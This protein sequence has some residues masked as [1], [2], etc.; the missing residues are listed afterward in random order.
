ME[1]SLATAASSCP[2]VDEAT[3]ASGLMDL[4]DGMR[5]LIVNNDYGVKKIARYARV[6]KVSPVPIL[7]VHQLVAA[8]AARSG[9]APQWTFVF[10]EAVFATGLV[11]EGDIAFRLPA[12]CTAVA[13]NTRRLFQ[14]VHDLLF[15][16]V[17]KHEFIVRFAACVKKYF[18]G[19]LAC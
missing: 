1:R 18:F 11:I 5:I 7:E 4:V 12:I 2:T 6:A 10:H 9:H 3:T 13:A 8:T 14:T 16:L 19:D 15:L 17:L